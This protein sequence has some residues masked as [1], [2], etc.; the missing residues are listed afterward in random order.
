[1]KALFKLPE[2][3]KN[4]ATEKVVSIDLEQGKMENKLQNSLILLIENVFYWKIE[5]TINYRALFCS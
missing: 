4:K 2:S 5:R 3:T 1:M